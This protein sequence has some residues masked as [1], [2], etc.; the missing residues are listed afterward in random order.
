METENQLSHFGINEYYSP[1][2]LIAIKK[3]FL[4]IGRLLVETIIRLWQ[5]RQATECELA[6]MNVQTPIPHDQEPYHLFQLSNPDLHPHTESD[7]TAIAM[8]ASEVAPVIQK[9]IVPNNNIN[10]L[11]PSI[12]VLYVVSNMQHPPALIPKTNPPPVALN[13]L[14]VRNT[15]AK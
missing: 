9:L 3:R 15:E 6:A 7:M 1:Q 5:S 10:L 8:S 14:P 11:P 12:G 2:L 13:S 4:A